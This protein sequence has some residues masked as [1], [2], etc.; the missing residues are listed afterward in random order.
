MDAPLTRRARMMSRMTTLAR[1]LVLLAALGFLAFGLWYVIDPVAPMLAIGVPVEGPVAATEFRAFYGGLE[2]GLAAFLLGCAWKRSALV[3]G[4]WLVL[5]ANAG[6]GLV[7]VGALAA[8]APWSSF[9]A[10]ALAWELGFAA[11]AALALLGLRRRPEG[12]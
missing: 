6:I 2:L 11:L 5:L 8:G 7:R 4:L 3:P 12:R 1:L 9:F 10:Y